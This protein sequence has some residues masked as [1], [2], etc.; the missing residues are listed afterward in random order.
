LTIDAS[1]PLHA[2]ISC[3]TDGLQFST[4]CTI[5]NQKLSLEN[6]ESIQVRFKR[7][8]DRTQL[9]VTLNELISEKIKSKLL[10]EDQKEEAVRR[11]TMN[12]CRHF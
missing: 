3:I 5:G 9:T 11:L 6:L 8:D 10:E 1:L 12:D 7:E 4:H 2:L